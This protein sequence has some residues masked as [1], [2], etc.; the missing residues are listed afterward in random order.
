MKYGNVDLGRFDKLFSVQDKLVLQKFIDTKELLKENNKFWAQKF[1][2]DNAPTAMTS[3]GAASFKVMAIEKSVNPMADFVAPFSET[4]QSDK[5]GF[6]YYL[7]TIPDIGKGWSETAMERYQK[8]LMFK[9]FGNDSDI[10]GQYVDEVQKLYDAVNARLSNMSA[11]LISKGQIVTTTGA[12]RGQGLAYRCKAEIP[13]DNFMT[14]GSKVWSDATC[15]IPLQM[16]IIEEEARTQSGFTGIFQW[17]IDEAFLKTTFLNNSFVRSMVLNYFA[18]QR[19]TYNSDF[20]VTYPMLLEAMNDDTVRPFSMIIPIFEKQV[21]QTLTAR[22]SVRGWDTTIAVLRP[23]GYAGV[24]KY[25]AIP[26]IVVSNSH[27]SSIVQK[28]TALIDG[29]IFGL[30][31]Y[32][33]DNGGYAQWYS[34]MRGSCVPALTEFPYHFII[35]MTAKDS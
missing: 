24:I 7:G 28:T 33:K 13:A 32:V 5:D 9:E 34:D 30:I 10:V 27:G 26:E 16:S 6:S 18:G 15:N 25:T 4:P 31:N 35:D 21:E 8:E 3:D 20:V 17:E 29:G 14:C 2:K 22:T 1:V 23:A 11:Q 19:I 12:G